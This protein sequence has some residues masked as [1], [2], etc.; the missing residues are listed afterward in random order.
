MFGDTL[1][2]SK[3]HPVPFLHKVF[4]CSQQ[5]HYLLFVVSPVSIQHFNIYGASQKTPK[6]CFCISKKK[7]NAA[8]QYNGKIRRKTAIF[9]KKKRGFRLREEQMFAALYRASVAN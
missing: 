9:Q 2:K 5:D 4:E 7:K 1:D 8:N 3:T 6:S